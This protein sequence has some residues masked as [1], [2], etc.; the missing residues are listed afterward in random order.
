MPYLRQ[1][2]AARG[3]FCSQKGACELVSDLVN[4]AML[5]QT[6]GSKPGDRR[7]QYE[8]AVLLFFT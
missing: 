8:P 5:G 6:W 2:Q 7:G 3:S 1:V 4:R